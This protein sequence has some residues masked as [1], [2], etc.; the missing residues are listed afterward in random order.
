MKKEII[1]KKE[2]LEKLILNNYTEI[3][4]IIYFLLVNHKLDDIIDKL[5]EKK[6]NFRTV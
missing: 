6:S 5:D 3:N 2:K 1:Q 4:I